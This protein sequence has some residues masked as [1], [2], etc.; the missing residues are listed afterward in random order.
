[1]GNGSQLLLL[2]VFTKV[3]FKKN[4]GGRYIVS[5]RHDLNKK[6]QSENINL[7]PP[8]L[9]IENEQVCIDKSLNI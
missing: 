5:N 1:M 9:M 8:S 2:A 6:T 3:Y 7:K 4:N